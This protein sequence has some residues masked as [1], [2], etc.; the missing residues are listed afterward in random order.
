[1]FRLSLPVLAALGLV[2]CASAPPAYLAAPAD[3]TRAV[4]PVP[5]AYVTAG[6]ASPAIVEPT[7]WEQLNRDVTPKGSSHAP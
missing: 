3:P 2:G 7:D 4:R 5:A 1:M 6:A